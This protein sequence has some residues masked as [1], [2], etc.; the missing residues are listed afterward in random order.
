MKY[1]EE[2]SKKLNELLIKNYNAEKGYL[3]AIEQVDSDRLK[4]FF[5]RRATERSEFAESLRKEILQYGQVPEDSG[6][7]KGVAHRNWMRLKALF[8]S[9]NE[10]AILEEAIRGEE[11]SLEVYNEI[12]E[13]KTLPPTIDN[14]LMKHKYAIQAAINS[15]K[16]KEA[17]VS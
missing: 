6:S 4:L 12:M 1:S 16:V 13:D 7:F 8:S 3:N 10:E 11:A 9:N 17:L 2:I 14:L 5:K 15:E